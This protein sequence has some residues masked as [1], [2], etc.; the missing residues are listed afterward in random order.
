M[1]ERG[2][3]LFVPS[4]HITSDVS[5]VNFSSLLQLDRLQLTVVC[6]N[7]RVV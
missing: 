7:R 1:I 3:P 2:D 6:C 5:A 4:F